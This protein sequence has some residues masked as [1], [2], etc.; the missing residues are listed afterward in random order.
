VDKLVADL[1]SP[2][3]A[4]TLKPVAEA[5][6]TVWVILASVAAVIGVLVGN[7]WVI[8]VPVGVSLAA[9]LIGLIFD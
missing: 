5:A 7:A 3:P 2:H 8:A 1:P 4:G 9:F 6:L